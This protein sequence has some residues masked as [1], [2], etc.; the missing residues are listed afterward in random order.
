MPDRSVI[1]A[2]AIGALIACLGY[3]TLGAKAPWGFVLPFR[4]EKLAALVLVAV[5]VSTATVLFQTISFNR[6]LTPE[7]MGFDA[8]YL[9]LLTLGVLVF[10]GTGF[11]ALNPL[12]VFAV[13]TSL[14]MIAGIFLFGTLLNQARADLLRMILTGII[15]GLLFRSLASFI[16]RLIDPNEFSVVQV[17]SY[18]RF[19]T[20]ET[21]LLV[22][23]APLTVTAVAIAWGMR[24]RLD[25]ISLGHDTAI[26]LGEAPRRTQMLVLL[27]V[28]I[29]VSASTAFVGPVMLLGLLVVSLAHALRPTPYHATLFPVA[30]LISIIMLVGGQT[31]LERVL[32]LTTPLSVVV[33]MLGGVVFLILV[34]KG[35]SK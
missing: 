1:A 27:L 3:M 20:I 23:A 18:A 4:G 9:L 31:V 21:D 2:L 10:G 15:F 35:P 13:T 17:R 28:G 6:I 16:Q 19:N 24:R 5:A 29:L 7:I 25:V 8:L 30:G 33:S 14:L 22:I 12:L 34:L 26:S 32:G 11:T